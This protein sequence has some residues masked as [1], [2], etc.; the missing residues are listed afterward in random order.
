MKRRAFYALTFEAD[1][2]AVRDPTDV[3][4]MG[5]YFGGCHGSLTD[6]RDG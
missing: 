6:E 4:V 3:R 2:G 5:V 1:D